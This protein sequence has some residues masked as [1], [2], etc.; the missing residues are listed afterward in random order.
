M[1]IWS[2]RCSNEFEWQRQTGVY[3]WLQ[4]MDL[5]IQ[6]LGGYGVFRFLDNLFN[7]FQTLFENGEVDSIT[8]A[9]NYA[10]IEKTRQIAEVRL[11]LQSSGGGK[12]VYQQRWRTV[13]ILF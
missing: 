10:I 7:A 11:F 3:A 6:E 5:R 12:L 8:L 2:K 13:I 1:N 9:D 4:S